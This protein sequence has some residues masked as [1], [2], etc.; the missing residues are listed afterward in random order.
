MNPSE[1][2]CDL[3]RIS[4]YL[5]EHLDEAGLAEFETHLTDCVSCQDELQRRA[6]EPAVW[7]DAARLLGHE[8]S[9]PTTDGT[10]KKHERQFASVL[11]ALAPTDDP[12]MLG[13]IGEYEV[14]GIV[15]VG[16]M[17]A[18]LKG[19]DR[20]LRRVVAIKVMAP[21]LADSGSARNRFRR[22]ARAAAAITHDNVI[23]IYG[24]SEA[25]E[26]PYLVMPFARGPSLQARIDES[27]PMTATEVVRIGRQIASGL[28]AAH[29]QGLVHRDIKP[30]NILLSEGI[31]RLWITD[32]GVARAID[33]A[34]MTQTGLIAGGLGAVAGPAGPLI[35]R[36]AENVAS[37]VMGR[38]GRRAA[39]ELGVSPPAADIV[40]TALENDGGVDALARVGPGG[41]IADAGPATAG[42][43][44]Y[45]IQRA[46][47]GGN[48]AREAI[49][50]RAAEAGQEIKSDLDAFLGKPRGLREAGR[51][52]SERTQRFRQQAY[53]RAY[54][55]PIDYASDAGRRI[56]DVFGRIPPRILQGAIRDAN[57][58]MISQG[59]QNAQILAEIAEDGSVVFRE[60]P[61]MEQ[62]DQI[63]RALDRAGAGT[64]LLGRVT[65]EAR[66]PR[67]L[68]GELREAIKAANPYYDRALALGGEKI[69]EDKALMVGRRILQ[70]NFS[71]EDVADALD[72]ASAAELRQARTGLRRQIDEVM[73]NVRRSIG[74]TNMDA[75]EGIRAMRELS[76][77][78]VQEKIATVLGDE[79][80]GKLDFG[81]AALLDDDELESAGPLTLNYAAPEQLFGLPLSAATDQFALG[82]LLYQLLVGELPQ[83]DAGGALAL[84]IGLRWHCGRLGSSQELKA[85]VARATAQQPQERYATVAA[86]GEDVRAY[87]DAR[88][89]AALPGGLLVPTCASLLSAHRSRSLLGAAL[90]T[91]LLVGLISSLQFAQRANEEA[92]RAQEALAET[93]YHLAAAN[94]WLG[95]QSAYANAL[96]R[97]FGAS[98]DLQAQTDALFGVWREAHELRDRSPAETDQAA[99]LGYSIGRH[100]V[101]RNDYET[102]RKVLEPWV[103]EGYGD[104]EVLMLG[105][106]LL[107]IAYASSGEPNAAEPLLREVEQWYAS[108]YGAETA[109]HIAVSNQ[110]AM[111][112]MEPADLARS[113]ALLR[114]GIRQS[115]DPVTNAYFYNQLARMLRLR[116]DFAGAH[117]LFREA[118]AGWGT[119]RGGERSGHDTLRLNLA[120]Y[121]VYF[122]QDL[123]R[124]EELAK[125]VLQE[126]SSQRGE[127]RETG[128]ALVTLGQARGY[129]GELDEAERLAREGLEVIDRFTRPGAPVYVDSA[130]FLAE[131]LAEQGKFAEATEMLDV[132]YDE[133]ASVT[134]SYN[135]HR[136]VLAQLYATALRDGSKA[137][138]ARC[139]AEYFDERKLGQYPQFKF[140]WDR[141]VSLGLD[142]ECLRDR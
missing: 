27:G 61:N 127:N 74:D 115:E 106:H 95:A 48:T 33:D 108:S 40:A 58:E 73:A 41:M 101:F 38:E 84:E 36:G 117:Q 102:G 39:T 83:R 52:I 125:L 79:Q 25:N 43:L 86:L 100:F 142:A 67:R 139:E 75:R 63:K 98:E 6:A 5:D 134:S 12:D 94:R 66:R 90:V 69:A 133:H 109:D 59:R 22:E 118:L 81:V 126:D 131:L 70:P 68:A 65:E 60:M 137:A 110:L 113:E 140:F 104:P 119:V 77:R 93:E 32:F 21:H 26:L 11:D 15:G 19:F 64:D 78:A 24:V 62:L 87:L 54:A 10:I 50:Q 72:G 128:W 45:S 92:A 31:E 111:I 14:S 35:G 23:E 96:Q 80:A 136:M 56:E 105:K 47:P 71:R 88:P 44:D 9:M 8:D 30:A 124:A 82:V 2:T 76:S 120:Q 20:S 97:L 121:E 16:G 123:E 3:Q 46:G 103:R 49:T 34:S 129:A 37:Y 4:D 85:I 91:A 17:G 132:S 122:S 99:K 53:D 130:A 55:Q 42:V 114:T 29:E 116:G 138:D 18:V 135:H 13:R 57:E 112:T 107:G 141:L 51:E 7:S 89:V 28:A 1:Q